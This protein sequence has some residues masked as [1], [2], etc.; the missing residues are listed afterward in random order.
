MT[1]ALCADLT[2]RAL[3]RDFY[4]PPGAV[5][6]PALTLVE[7]DA[8]DY[9]RD[10]EFYRQQAGFISAGPAIDAV[11]EAPTVPTMLK[12]IADGEPATSAVIFVDAH[13]AT[14]AARL[15]ARFPDMSDLSPRTSTPASATTRSRSS[16]DLQSYSLVLDTQEGQVQDAW[17]RA[18]RLIHE[19]YVSTIDPSWTTGTGIGAVDRAQRVLPRVQPSTGAQ[20]VVDGGTDR[21]THLEYLR[22]ARPRSCPAARWRN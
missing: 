16:A 9:L 6:L 11:A 12:L 13:A 19:R 2:Q 21:R 10:H 4:T 15:A 7:R 1:L 20:R 8:E 18:A 17:E 14:T 3:E 22:A 5:P